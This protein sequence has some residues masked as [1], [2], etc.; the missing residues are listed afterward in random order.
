MA[1]GGNSGKSFVPTII[2]ALLAAWGLTSGSGSSSFTPG[3]RTAR[4]NRPAMTS[5][6]TDEQEYPHSAA[7]LLENFLATAPVGEDPDRPW[8]QKTNP[9]ET[10]PDDRKKYGVN[11]LIATLPGP[12]SPAL[13]SEFDNDLDAIVSAASDAG[14][15]L[16]SFDLP[17]QEINGDK[18]E[19]AASDDEDSPLPALAP[20]KVLTR[21]NAEKAK[22][23]QRQ[24]GIILFHSQFP[25]NLLVLFIVGETQTGGINKLPLRDALDQIVSCSPWK[26]S[27]Q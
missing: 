27:H 3:N 15:T 21:R 20:R 5:T 26:S 11:F 25:P 8:L 16:D 14:Y 6:S 4:A 24:P 1:E 12:A 13:R 18:S 22:R 19:A 7:A 17:W 2:V 10:L 9:A 23:W